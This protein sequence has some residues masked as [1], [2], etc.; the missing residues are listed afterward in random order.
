[1]RCD[2]VCGDGEAMCPVDKLEFY[3]VSDASGVMWK[4]LWRVLDVEGTQSDLH[5]RGSYGQVQSAW[6]DAVGS[7]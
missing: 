2:V 6:S 4:S 5:L 1:M 7:D 3:P